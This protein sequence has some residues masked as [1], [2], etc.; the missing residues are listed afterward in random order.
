MV[1]QEYDWDPNWVAAEM[2]RSVYKAVGGAQI[3]PC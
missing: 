1:I 2:A 3:V